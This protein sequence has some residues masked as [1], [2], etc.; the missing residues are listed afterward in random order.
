MTT[1][2]LPENYRSELKLERIRRLAVVSGLAVF[3]V[4]V[5]NIILLSPLFIFFVSTE[6]ELMRHLTAVKQSPAFLLTTEIETEIAELN[7]EINSLGTR[8]HSPEIARAILSILERRPA[9]IKIS[10]IVFS[11][12]VPNR[13]QAPQISISGTASTRESLINFADSN[14]TSGFFKKVYSPISNL[15]KETN[16]DYFLVLDLNDKTGENE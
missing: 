3:A 6:N 13:N 12:A 7:S 8:D 9:G 15:L 5:V 10:N 4:V 11:S 2:L 14:K 1:N 16:L